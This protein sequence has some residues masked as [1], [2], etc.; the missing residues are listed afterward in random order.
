MPN[1][2]QF[3]VPAASGGADAVGGDLLMQALGGMCQQVAVLVK[4]LNSP[5][6]TPLSIPTNFATAPGR[7]GDYSL[8]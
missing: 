5:E 7:V 2:M 1:Q 8:H 4:R 6:T 3:V